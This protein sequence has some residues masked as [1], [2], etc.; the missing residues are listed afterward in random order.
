MALKSDHMHPNS[1]IK[2]QARVIFQPY[3]FH[4]MQTGVNLIADA[5]KP[6]LGPLPRFVAVEGNFRD[7]PPEILDSAATIARRIIQLE[8]RNA[9]MGAMYLRQV[10]WNLH[11]KAGDGTAAAAVLFQSIF[12]QSITYITAGGQPMQFKEHLLDGMRLILRQLEQMTLPPPQD[13]AGL[14]ALAE[15]ICYDR[16]LS[17]VLGEVFETIGPYGSLEF[18]PSQG[19]EVTAK[20]ISGAYW[21]GGLV[22][23]EFI[24]DIAGQRTD[25]YDAGILI[26]DFEIEE[27]EELNPILQAAIDANLKGLVIVLE[28]ISEKAGYALLNPRLRERITVI[29]VRPIALGLEERINYS[30]DLGLM[31]GGTLVLKSAG[32]AP[33]AVKALHFGRARQLWADMGHLGLVGGKGEA[34]AVRRLISDMRA[35]FNQLDDNEKRTLVQNRIGKLQGGAAQLEAGGISPLE[36]E[37][38]QELAKRT[39]EVMRGTLREGILPGGGVALFDCRN[40]LLTEMQRTKDTDRRAAFRIL[41]QAVREPLCTLLKNAG[42]NTEDILVKIQH[43]GPGWGYDILRNRVVYMTQIGLVDCAA[44][45][46]EAVHSAVSG[47]ALAITTDVLVHHK[48]PETD[49]NP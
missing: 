34:L 33:S 31:T 36:V 5:V 49:Y 37:Q 35:R 19:R 18:P 7:H 32:Q 48:K 24:T 44:T 4:H 23:K 6:T 30:Q 27:P 20:Y 15:A 12:N 26:T 16:H 13:A 47:A 2:S 21:E 28:K 22:R 11:E 1:P 39:A 40:L 29:P 25:L 41:A 43:R 9:D 17:Q 42:L 45:I 14:A 3:T 8:D 10:L 38:R 46:R